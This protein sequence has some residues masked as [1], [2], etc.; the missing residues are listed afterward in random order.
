MDPMV[1]NRRGTRFPLGIPRTIT[2]LNIIIIIITGFPLGIL[3]T[4]TTI[5]I[6]VTRFPLG[7]PTH[8]LQQYIFIGIK[9][10]S[11]RCVPPQMLTPAPTW[12]QQR[13]GRAVTRR[14]AATRQHVLAAGGCIPLPPLTVCLS[15][16]LSPAE[17][18]A[19][20]S[21]L[22]LLRRR[23][24]VSPPT[25][26]TDTSSGPPSLSSIFFFHSFS[27][28]Q[29]RRWRAQAAVGR[30]TTRTAAEDWWAAA[31]LFSF[32]L[33]SSF[34]VIFFFLQVAA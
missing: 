20:P 21:Y 23:A 34:S 18:A 8:S 31:L 1:A 7:I 15:V 33:C 12:S 2:T 11:S 6:V 17:R 19:F 29:R 4:T 5:N 10:T 26:P 16:S 22:F 24:P 14:R 3:N 13:R 28:W 32:L 27:R 9:R 25:F 30:S